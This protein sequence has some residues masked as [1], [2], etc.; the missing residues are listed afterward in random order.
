MAVLGA[1][2]GL[3]IAAAVPSGPPASTLGSAHAAVGSGHVADALQAVAHVRTVT[4]L[5]AALPAAAPSVR[6]R[7][8]LPAVPA[9]SPPRRAFIATSPTAIRGPPA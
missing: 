6:D 3:L 7:L 2:A 1:L 9:T 8:R 5:P 4:H